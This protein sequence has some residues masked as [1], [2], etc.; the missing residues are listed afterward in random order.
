MEN[1]QKREAADAVLKQAVD[2][3]VSPQ[4]PR[5]INCLTL[6]PSVI[7]ET[8]IKAQEIV[9]GLQ[10]SFSA[11]EELKRAHP[12]AFYAYAGLPL[13][14]DYRDHDNAHPQAWYRDQGIHWTN[15]SRTELVKVSDDFSQDIRTIIYGEKTSVTGN[16]YRYSNSYEFES[17]W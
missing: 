13:M 11:S 17:R 2:R 12:D 3:V 7:D 10:K 16:G 6:S 8:A 5:R 4:H 14:G 1:Q 9:R 15:K